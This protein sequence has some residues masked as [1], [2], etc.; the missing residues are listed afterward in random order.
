MGIIQFDYLIS[1]LDNKYKIA[2]ETG[3]FKGDTT[4]LLSKYFERV[5]TIE[6]DNKLYNE[7]INRIDN[8]N[9]KFYLGNSSDI[10]SSISDELNLTDSKILFWLDAHWS[11]DDRVN[12]NDSLWK[13]YNTN[14]GYVDNNI[15]D[16]PSSKNQVPLE[17]EI[18]N[19]YKYVKNEC[20][21]YIDDFDKIDKK[22]MK[23][24]KN[25]CFIF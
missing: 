9:I 25:K 7:V 24:L 6:I 2:V 11:G 4:L 3:T 22:T 5:Y 13:G 8:K 20:L 17:E 16:I 21:L 12:W 18:M 14:T 1:L 23:G 10:I 15:E 19:I